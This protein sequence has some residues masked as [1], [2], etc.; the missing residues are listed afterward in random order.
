MLQ[1]DLC[2]R[3]NTLN[4]YYPYY[5]NNI[6]E[7]KKRKLKIVITK[8]KNLKKNKKIKMQLIN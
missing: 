1:I 6:S 7:D 4:T 3:A 5:I 8:I 2:I